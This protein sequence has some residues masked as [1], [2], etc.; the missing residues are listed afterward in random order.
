MSFNIV[1][2][3]IK[4][5]PNAKEDKVIELDNQII[6][7]TREKPVENKANIAVLKLL[8]EFYKKKGFKIQKI[9]IVK[10]KN[11]KSKVV[12]VEIENDSKKD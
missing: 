8:K 6:I 5:K 1:N 12:R 7:L 10:G 9:Y 4:V 11:S 3:N 2:L